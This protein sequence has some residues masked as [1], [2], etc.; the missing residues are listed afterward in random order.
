MFSDGPV[1]PVDKTQIGSRIKEIRKKAGLTQEQFGERIG[2]HKNQVYY[3]E[4][5]KSIPSDDFIAAVSREFRVGYLWLRTGEADER[6]PVDDR[7]I[8]WLR[9]NPEVARELRVKA[10]LD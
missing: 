4:V 5:G 7:L 2:F 1:P 6:D 3:V 9:R 8:E 10:G